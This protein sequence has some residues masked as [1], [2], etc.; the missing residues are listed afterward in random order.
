[1]TWSLILT[2]ALK[3]LIPIVLTAIVTYYLKPVRDTYKKGQREEKKEAWEEL[4]QNLTERVE[5]LE[6]KE[7]GLDA[8]LDEVLTVVNRNHN[9][10]K[11]DLKNVEDKNTAAFIQIYQRGLIIDGKEYINNKFITP[12]QLTN[13]EK[14]FAQY[15]KWGGNGDVDPW[16]KIIRELPIHYPSE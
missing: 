11:Q 13:Y 15:K 6:N 12:M 9:E 3:W 10:I 4:A 2:E 1:M 8:K 14:R 16:I 7:N 5:K